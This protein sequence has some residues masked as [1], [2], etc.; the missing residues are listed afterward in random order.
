M[1]SE[2]GVRPRICFSVS[3]PMDYP[4]IQ[5]PVNWSLHH[6]KSFSPPIFLG[7]GNHN[8]LISLCEEILNEMLQESILR[9]LIF[10]VSW[11]RL[12]LFPSAVV[13][14]I[15]PPASQVF[16][17]ILVCSIIIKLNHFQGTAISFIV[18]KRTI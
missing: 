2:D 4:Q 12:F 7:E 5:N 17:D 14:N 8:S 16:G 11:V 1:S 15:V 18:Q 13:V 9:L 3:L 10:T 6:P